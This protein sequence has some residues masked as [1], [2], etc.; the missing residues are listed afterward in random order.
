MCVLIHCTGVWGRLKKKKS[1]RNIFG[2]YTSEKWEGCQVSCQWKLK[3]IEL[4]GF[5]RHSLL[6]PCSWMCCRKHQRAS[7]QGGSSSEKA[8]PTLRTGS[9]FSA[10]PALFKPKPSS[11]FHGICNHVLYLT[12]TY[13]SNLG[14]GFKFIS[15]QTPP[16]YQILNTTIETTIS[17][18]LTYQTCR[19]K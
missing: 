9:T 14:L 19:G 15:I 11:C 8:K 5:F 16:L 1:N 4:R 17:T 7:G 13:C 18:N 3:K 6:C 12:G 2:D 10:R